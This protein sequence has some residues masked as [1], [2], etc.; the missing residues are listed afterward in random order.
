V[1]SDC[2][3]AA[4]QP[5]D[6]VSPKHGEIARQKMRQKIGATADLVKHLQVLVLAGGV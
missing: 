1:F 4:E 2:D 6:D 5:H 3:D